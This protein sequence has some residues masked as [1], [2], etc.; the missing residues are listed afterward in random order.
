MADTNVKILVSAIDQ[1]SNVLKNIG[2]NIE[3]TLGKQAKTNVSGL[4]S[5]TSGLVGSFGRLAVAGAALGAGIAVVTQAISSLTSA[6]GGFIQDAIVMENSLTALSRISQRFGEDADLATQAAKDLASDGLISVATA[7]EGLQ[8]LM[9]AGMSLDKAVDLMGAYKD[10]AAFGRSAT[11]SMDQAVGNLSES[12]LTESSAIGNLSGQSENYNLILERGAAVLGKKVSQLSEAERAEA[13]YIGTMQLG[14]LVQGDSEVAATTMGGALSKLKTAQTELSATIGQ[15]LAPAVTM[16][17]QGFTNILGP[18]T[19]WLKGKMLGLQTAFIVLVSGVQMVLQAI[20]YGAKAMVQAASGDWEGA[21]ATARSGMGAIQTTIQNAQT[22]IYEAAVKSYGGQMDAVAEAT[23]YAV[24]KTNEASQKIMKQMQ[25]ETEEFERQM[26]KRKASQAE[27]LEDLVRSHIDKRN[28]LMRDL[29]DENDD[30]HRSMADRASDFKERMAE[31]KS[32]HEDKVNSIRIQLAEENEEYEEAMAERVQN[33]EDKIADMTASH[34]SKVEQLKR[35]MDKERVYGEQAN[36]W[37]LM[38]LQ[39][40]LEEE[41]AEYDRKLAQESEKQEQEIAKAQEKHQ[42]KL[43]DLEA[44]LLKEDEMYNSQVEKAVER[45]AKETARQQEEHNKRTAAFQ[46]QIDEENEIMAKHQADFDAVKNKAV[47]DDISR[48]KRKHEEENA[49][50]LAQ[51][52]RKMK[53]LAEQG[54]AQGATYG[55]SIKDAIDPKLAETEQMMEESGKE[56][57]EKYAN[58]IGSGALEAGRKF[59]DN[60]FGGMVGKINE[61]ASKVGVK[62]SEVIGFIGGD[63][64][65]FGA[66]L[67]GFKQAGGVV[68]GPIGQPVPIMA[69]GGEYVTPQGQTPKG[70]VAGAGV[71]FNVYLGMY[72]G[73]ESEKRN[74]AKDLYASLLQ[75]A[76]SQHKSVAEMMGG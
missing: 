15:A 38:D 69:H 42:K 60:L 26:A 59:I 17:A 52:E 23:D 39:A 40:A 45:D 73:T 48:L 31:M 65:K 71:T 76:N 53:E 50:A 12:F 30:F 27:Q 51:H 74:I 56:A 4:G 33:Y 44:A 75:L 10:Q 55:G 36:N 14:A 46:A 72:A 43:S 13:K 35:Q 3:D 41:N 20:G 8:K 34:E 49:E 57:G 66:K 18:A 2:K 63:L 21:V 25:K 47:E 6:V 37:K 62:P 5:A 11:L 1:A 54:S 58:A 61:A 70:G 28:S 67:L 16:L 9:T 68:P 64:A 29:A 32:S 7:A 24:D 19:E 22:K